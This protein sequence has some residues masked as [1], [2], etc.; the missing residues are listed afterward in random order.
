MTGLAWYRRARP[1]LGTLVEVGV[2]LGHEAVLGAMFNA[3]EQVQRLMSIHEATSDLSRLHAAQVDEPV[4]IHAWTHEVL[5]LAQCL[6][7]QTDGLFDVACGSGAWSV[8]MR[9][10]QAS[11][12]RHVAACRLDLGGVAK[13][14]AVDKAVDTALAAGVDA[15]WVNAGG[16]L[17]CQGVSLP[18]ALRDEA[19]GGVRPWLELTDGAMATSY[20]APGSRS[21]LHGRRQS[22]HVSVAAPRCALADALTK[23]VAQ[24]SAVSDELLVRLNALHGAQAWIHEQDHHSNFE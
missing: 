11:A 20:F 3:I 24:A 12:V 5:Q 19:T 6:N 21:S 10:D 14:W 13:G 22:V 23:V 9:G 18:V 1:L 15:V 16:D 2:P 17:R 8:Q 7:A 4:D